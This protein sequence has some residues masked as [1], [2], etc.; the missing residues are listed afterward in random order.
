M[1]TIDK[2]IRYG[3]TIGQFSLGIGGFITLCVIFFIINFYSVQIEKK[4]IWYFIILFLIT[5]YLILDGYYG[6]FKKKFIEI[7]NSEIFIPKVSLFSK[8]F[9]FRLENVRAIMVHSAIYGGSTITFN[10]MEPILVSGKPKKKVE[11]HSSK[12]TGRFFNELY[13][14]LKQIRPDLIRET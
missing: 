14:Y 12:L 7:K 4:F 1:K 8:S 9:S 2:K 11:L 3:K 6:T 5:V 13:V 10:L